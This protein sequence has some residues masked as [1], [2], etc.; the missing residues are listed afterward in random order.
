M[1]ALDPVNYRE[2]LVSVITIFF[3]AEKFIEESIRS[4]LNQTYNN[5]ELI[6]V[7]D[8]STDGSTEIAR[9][10]KR[11]NDPPIRYF[12][13]ENHLNLGTS[14]SRN[15]GIQ[16]SKGTYIAFIDADDIWVPD[17]LEIQI[18]HFH[19]NP[20]VGM[21]YGREK[22]WYSW[23]QVGRKAKA[24][25]ILDH[26]IH[27]DRIINPPDLIILFLKQIAKL[28]GICNIM[29]KRE[30][31]E[32]LNGFENSFR[33]LYED[34][35]II[36]KVCLSFPVYVSNT[37]VAFYRQHRDSLCAKTNGTKVWQIEGAKYLN[38]LRSYMIDQHVSNKKVWAAWRFAVLISKHQ[39]LRK[40][41]KLYRK[42][43]WGLKS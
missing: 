10:F 2:P 40:I 9:A 3:N 21:V 17:K 43:R 27:A 37:I 38:W 16:M 42:L 11:D 24:D 26:M 31:L 18:K 8:G 29:F 34:Q 6:L 15:L 28:P 1:G 19:Q 33:T 35:V 23:N 20:T 22:Y 41:S 12:C 36:S 39:W 5:W 14:A 30:V 32:K 13:H 4:V 25:S 7:D